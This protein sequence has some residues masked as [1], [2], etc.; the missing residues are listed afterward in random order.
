[1]RLPPNNRLA[2]ILLGASAVASLG[3]WYIMIFVA[4]PER[5][6]A[7]E[8]AT[9]LLPYLLIESEPSWPFWIW[10]VLPI[11]LFCAAASA[12]RCPA[13][14]WSLLGV[15]L[16]VGLCAALSAFV[17]LPLALWVGVAAYLLATQWWLSR[18]SSGP[19]AAAT[20]LS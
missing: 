6:T 19:P 11:L 14:P 15:T 8:H 18:R 4:V 1:M 12:W 20:E 7:L 17:M 10:A 16:F 3:V 9:E 13:R 5:H 2:S